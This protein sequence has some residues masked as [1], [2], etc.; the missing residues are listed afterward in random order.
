VDVE[1]EDVNQAL[2]KAKKKKPDPQR[3]YCQVRSK[4]GV[5]KFVEWYVWNFSGNYYFTGQRVPDFSSRKSIESERKDFL[6]EDFTHAIDHEMGQPIKS[7]SGVIE[8]M[9]R[10]NSK[11]EDKALLS[12]LK[13][14]ADKLAEA[15]TQTSNRIHRKLSP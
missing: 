6:L 15:W 10:S 3:F 12:L 5:F 13:D 8:L 11:G 9:L 4:S 14:T 7:L 1:L 2:K